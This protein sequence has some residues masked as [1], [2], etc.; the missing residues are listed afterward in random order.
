[1]DYS[2]YQSDV[3]QNL[4]NSYWNNQLQTP[5]TDEAE[6]VD[7]QQEDDTENNDLQNKYDD[8]LSQNDELQRQLDDYDFQKNNDLTFLNSMFDDNNGHQPDNFTDEANVY[9]NGAK[10]TTNADIAWLKTKNKSVNLTNLDQTI[11]S[12]LNSLPND[13]KQ[14]LVATSGNDGDVHVPNSKHY[15]G[16]AVDLRYNQDIY[17]YIS[18]DPNLQALGLKVLPPNHGTAPHIHIERKKY[19]GKIKC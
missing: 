13:Y 9:R 2:V 10:P 17:N 4:L 1:M 14:S 6:Q 16:E 19:G 7:N 15:K 5:T 11:G 18:K 3:L 12:Y 8:L